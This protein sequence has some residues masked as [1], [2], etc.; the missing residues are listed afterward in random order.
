MIVYLHAATNN[1]AST[2]FHQFHVAVQS[3]G[4][5]SRVRSD[6]GGEN[7]D[8]AWFML[9]H[10]QRGPDRG[11]HIAGRSVHNQRIERLWRDLFL[12]CTYVFY[13]L[14]YCMENF[15]ILEPSNECHLFAL[16]YVFLPRIQRNLDLFKEGHS[17]GPLSTEHNS[18][19]EQL[20]IRGMLSVANSDLGTAHEFADKVQ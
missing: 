18:S 13:Y 5:P 14:F 4:L 19:P 9:N 16:R 17:R 11:S 3:Y 10:P 7:V 6:K 8:V 20:W 12:G 15:H 2:V 1:R